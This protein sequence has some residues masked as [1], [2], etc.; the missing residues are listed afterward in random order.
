MEIKLAPNAGFCFGVR[1]AI[2]KGEKLIEEGKGP[3]ATLGP[4]IH[5]PQEVARLESLGIR[6]YDELSDIQERTFSSVHMAL[7]LR[8]TRISRKAATRILIAPVQR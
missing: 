6:S 4:L 2:N 3:I 8:F 7:R 5:N 1:A